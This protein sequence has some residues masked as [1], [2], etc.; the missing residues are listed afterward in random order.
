MS[1]HPSLA[2]LHPATAR[3][4]QEDLDP[5]DI[6]ALLDTLEPQDSQVAEE[7]TDHQ[8]PDNLDTPDSQER[9]E[10]VELENQ[11]KL[12][13]ARKQRKARSPRD[14]LDHQETQE[15]PED[16]EEMVCQEAQDSQESQDQTR[17]TAPAQEEPATPSPRDTESTK[18]RSSDRAGDEHPKTNILPP[19][20]LSSLASFFLPFGIFGELNFE[21][22]ASSSIK[23]SIFKLS[24]Y[25]LFVY[26]ATAEKLCKTEGINPCVSPDDCESE[27]GAVCLTMRDDHSKKVCCI[28]EDHEDEVDPKETTPEPGNGNENG[29][30]N[31]NGNGIN[32][33]GDGDDK[34]VFCEDK[35][36]PKTGKPDC[37]KLAKYCDHPKYYDL[38][39]DLCAKTCNRCG[40]KGKNGS[41]FDGLNPR[42]GKSDCPKMKNLCQ[43]PKYY[44]LMKSECPKSCG[45]CK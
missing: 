1:I 40:G 13:T 3:N 5:M 42:T 41:C 43:H 22:E 9:A 16:Q 38:M 36:N 44:T 30:E 39:T 12:G 17:L 4:A 35:R 45:Y 19:S 24:L 15:T 2:Q 11:E 21:I 29:N 14:P 31:G 18:R 37:P 20:I 7:T 10:L 6:W 26:F 28:P 8:D 23:M 32:G 25:F 33:N 34:D 27:H